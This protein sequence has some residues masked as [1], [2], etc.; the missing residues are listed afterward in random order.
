MR[1]PSYLTTIHIFS[2]SGKTGAQGIQGIQGIQGVSGH[3]GAQGISGK[4]GAQGIQGVS[5]HTGAQGIQGVSGITPTFTFNGSGSTIIHQN[6][7]GNVY[8][9]NIYAPS[10]KTGVQGIQGAQGIQGISG[11]TGAQGIQGIQGISGITPTFTFN[12][13]GSTIINQHKVGNAYTLNIYAP[14]GKTGA[15]KGRKDALTFRK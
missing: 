7:I 11:H 1:Q 5:G 6:K 14:S 4:T 15:Q 2:P 3:T 13:S 10:G 9:L 8:T 12:G